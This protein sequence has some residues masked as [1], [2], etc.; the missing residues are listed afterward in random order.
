MLYVIVITLL[1]GGAALA[2]ERS[3]R[4][5]RSRTRWIWVVAILAS[6]AVPTVIASVSIQIPSLVTP[7]VTRKIAALREMTA[8]HVAPLTWVRERTVNSAAA[9]NLNR[10]LR[11]CWL[12]V[13][14]ALFVALL[15]NGAYASWRKRRWRERTVAGV[16]VY[17]APD[18]GPAVVGLLRPRIV[19]PGWLTETS[20]SHQAMV[21]A[22]EQAH[23]AGRD[24]QVLTVAL[25]LLVLMPWNLPLWWQLRRLRYAIEVDC[26]A[27]VLERGLDTRQYGETL[28][29][30]SEWPVAYVGSVA[31]MAESRSFLEE[32]ITLML[33]DPVRWGSTATLASGCLALALAA[34]AIQ[35]TPPNVANPGDSWRQAASVASEEELDRYV[36]F[37]VLGGHI[38][39]AVR[40]DGPHLFEQQRQRPPEEMFADSESEFWTKSGQ[41]FTFARDERGVVS[42]I[43]EH[44]NREYSFAWPRVEAATARQILARN[45][46]RSQSQTPTPGSEPMV[47]RLIEGWRTGSPDYDEMVPGYREFM[48]DRHVRTF[49]HSWYMPLGSIQSIEF[50]HVDEAGGDAYEVHLDHGRRELVIYLNAD[51][52]IEWV[53]CVGL[54]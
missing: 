18:A 49:L 2:A 50:R 29:H 40:R 43:V 6:L 53:E 17:I 22:H 54:G 47:R 41:H 51:G 19:V 31:A 16:K 24:P 13:S 5:R 33:R 10:T 52:R 1:L 39:L 37:Y 12:T 21:I 9:P 46:L 27:R 7:T 8:V 23:L 20:H 44:V 15:L 4:L 11:R 38:V 48:K 30:V 28:I 26:D 32:R 14:A 36:G 45:K 42:G 25:F 35:V 34:F 3:A